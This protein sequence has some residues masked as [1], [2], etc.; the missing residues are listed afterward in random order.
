MTLSIFVFFLLGILIE[1]LLLFD[2]AHPI[3]G[4]IQ[5]LHPLLQRIF[6]PVNLAASTLALLA[7]GLAFLIRLAGLDGPSMDIGTS[8]VGSVLVVLGVFVFFAA[9]AADL[10]IPVINE[11]S[12]LIV[13]CAILA[14]FLLEG[15]QVPWLPLLPLVLIPGII[16][17]FLLFSQKKLPP[18]LKALFY[19]WYLFTLMILPFQTGQVEA[20]LHATYTPIQAAVSGGLLLFMVIHGLFTA[21]FFLMVCSLIRPR[22]RKFINRLMPRLFTDDQVPPKSFLLTFA[23]CVVAI[24]LNQVLHIIPPSLAL[25]LCVM[26]AVQILSHLSRMKK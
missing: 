23:A 15:N 6:S 12:I 1:A 13:Q 5:S 10:F 7:A 20:F 24:L 8:L 14:S 3:N 4:Y 9:M 19:L 2:C 18:I 22:N 17:L 16:S 25:T 11:Q 26:S 21:R